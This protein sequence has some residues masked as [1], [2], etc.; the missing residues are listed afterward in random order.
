MSL[1]RRAPVFAAARGLPRPRRAAGRA[2][3]RAGVADRA[4]ARGAGGE[5]RAAL[6]RPVHRDL[7][8]VGRALHRRPDRLPA[9]ARRRRRRRLAARRGRQH[10]RLPPPQGHGGDARAAGARRDRLAGARGRVLRAARDHAVHEPRAAARAGHRRP[11]LHAAHAA[12][13]AAPFNAV[14]HTAE[15]RRP[16]TGA[17]RYNIPN[18]GIFLWRLQPFR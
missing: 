15:M 7:R 10:H 2:A 8:G 13:R 18:I 12:A 14:A 17:G 1:D 16:E 5:R 3:A 11:A 9:A 6:R 4:G